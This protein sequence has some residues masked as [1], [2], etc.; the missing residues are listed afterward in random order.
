LPSPSS[1]TSSGVGGGRIGDELDD[2]VL[3]YTTHVSTTTPGKSVLG[4]FDH[5]YLRTM[6]GS[7]TDGW[8]LPSVMSD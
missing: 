1:G 3:Q 4:G 5:D 8:S 7:R 6:C 2:I